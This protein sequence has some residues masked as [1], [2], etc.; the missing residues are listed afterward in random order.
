M[1][2]RTRTIPSS[3]AFPLIS[4]LVGCG[5]GTQ[6]TDMSAEE[7]RRAAER[8]D[9]LAHEHGGHEDV[10]SV[11]E[12]LDGI[13]G[14]GGEIFGEA[15]YSPV[16][17]HAQLT[18]E[19]QQLAAAHRAAASALESYEEHECGAFPAATRAACPLLGQVASVEDIPGGARAQFGENVNVDAATAHVA[20]HLAYAQTVGREGMSGCPLY[21]PNVGSARSGPTTVDFVTDRDVEELRRRLAAHVVAVP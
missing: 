13:S 11:P 12:A 8:E 9:E 10:S 15:V 18:E 1:T 6:P 19:H 5:A 21:L 3:I 20:C 14:R 16:A 2:N 7:H 17:V 4:L